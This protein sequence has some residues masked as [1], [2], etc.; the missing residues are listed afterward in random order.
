MSASLETLSEEAAAEYLRLA[1]PLM[2]RHHVPATPHNYAVWYTY[3]SGENPALNAQIDALVERGAS[4][5]NEVSEELYVRFISEKGARSLERVR[6]DLSRLLFEVSES[7]SAAGN[8]ADAFHDSLGELASSVDQ[9][10]SMD[11]MRTLL[12]SLIAETRSMRDATNRM[13]RNFESKNDEIEELREQLI[14]ERRR[15]VTDP[16]TGLMNRAGLFAELETTVEQQSETRTPFSV[17]MLD[18]DRFKKIND[19]HGHLIG[20]RVIRFVAEVLRKNTKGKDT[21]ARYGGEEFLVLLPETRVHGAEALAETIRKTVAQAQLVRAGNKAPLGKITISAGVA[22][23]TDQEDVM[24]L[25]N[26]ADQALYQSK[27]S[28]RDRVT[29]G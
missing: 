21:A 3:V 27:Q 18:I 28:G 4:F 19:T 26:R 12:S 8:D 9:R 14:T 10:S 7:L 23:H 11:D 29:L 16:L 24:D 15:A 1:I 2:N 20:D 25:I 5:S 13:Q 6:T 17:V 22:E